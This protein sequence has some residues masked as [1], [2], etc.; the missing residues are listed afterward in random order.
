MGREEQP[1]Q[2]MDG[3]LVEQIE[4]YCMAAREVRWTEAAKMMLEVA[5]Q[6]DRRWTTP[7]LGGG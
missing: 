3:D 6:N 4:R 1:S 7:G 5:G 2:R